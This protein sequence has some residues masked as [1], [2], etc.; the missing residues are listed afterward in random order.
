MRP[1]V[2]S[3]IPYRDLWG[4]DG[5][6]REQLEQLIAT[7]DWRDI[8]TTAAGM[9]AIGW[10]NGIEDGDHIPIIESFV[11]DLPI[12]G[13]TLV[14]KLR[15][16]LSQV[17]FTDESLLAVLRLGV[18]G[19]ATT[20]ALSNQE[21]R[22][23]FVRAVTMANELVHRELDP[24][25]RTGSPE[26]L[27]ASEIRSKASIFDNPHVLLA[28]T[29]AFFEWARNTNRAQTPDELPLETDFGALTG[30]TPMEFAAGAYSMLGR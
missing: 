13:Q 27:M 18:A 21:F 19:A 22:D 26:D 20:N 16:D 17:L 24:P 11:L 2:I 15:S 1:Q 7:M 5:V 6:S 3:S 28:R 29:S 25:Q 4:G 30:L 12:Y 23:R 9:S 10:R 14:G 8:V